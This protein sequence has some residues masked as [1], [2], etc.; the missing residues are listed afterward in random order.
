MYSL[1]RA[2]IAYV[3]ATLA[4]GTV[5]PPALAQAQRLAVTVTHSGDDP[6]GKTLAYSVREELRRSALFEVTVFEE[7][8][9][10]IDLISID[11]GTSRDN[12]GLSSAIAASYTMRNG[13]PFQTD[14]PQTWYPIFLTATVHTVGRSRVDEAA[15]SIVATLDA[16]IER[17][18]AD[19]RR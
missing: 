7:S 17:F 12:E 3:F 13:V 5:P 4:A 1:R 14:N 8:V 15:K 11:A 2:T 6:V 10:R 9:F 18:K 16:A 19:S